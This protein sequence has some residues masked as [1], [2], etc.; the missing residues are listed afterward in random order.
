MSSV[1]SEYLA[2]INETE[3]LGARLGRSHPTN[4]VIYLKGELGAGKTSFVRGFIQSLGHQGHVK[5]PT[6][7]LI[8]P[9]QIGEV[10]IY[11]LDLYRLSDPEELEYL[12]LREMLSSGLC[13]IEWPEQGGPDLPLPDLTLHF[14]YHGEG[15]TVEIIPASPTGEK[16]LADIRA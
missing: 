7:T 13:L 1:Y 15:R 2:S 6:Y 5:S 10:S 16:W 9:Y 8:E 14:N 3:A 4:A 12:G 11:H